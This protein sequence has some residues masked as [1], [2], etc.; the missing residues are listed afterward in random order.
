VSGGPSHPTGEK[1][2]PPV[3]RRPLAGRGATSCSIGGSVEK[4]GFPDA[5]PRSAMTCNKIGAKESADEKRVHGDSGYHSRGACR[6][7]HLAEREKRCARRA[8]IDPHGTGAPSGRRP[9]HARSSNA[10]DL[11]H[12]STGDASRPAFTTCTAIVK[13]RGLALRS[14]QR[15]AGNAKPSAA[16]ILAASMMS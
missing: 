5:F 3:A 16:D 14:P 8:D 9:E 7:S 1:G 4:P 11:C 15:Q 10:H 2:P 6:L 13:Q 12:T